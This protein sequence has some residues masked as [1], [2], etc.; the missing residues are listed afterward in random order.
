MRI[1]TYCISNVELFPTMMITMITT[2]VFD[3]TNNGGGCELEENGV[4]SSS[5]RME[6]G[7]S[8][9]LCDD[10]KIEGDVVCVFKVEVCTTRNMED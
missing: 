8:P 7:N 4:K 2:G 1:I 6:T 3:E 5:A 10:N 9:N